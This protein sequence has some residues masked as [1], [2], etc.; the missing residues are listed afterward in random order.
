MVGRLLVLGARR[1]QNTQSGL[2][3]LDGGA[4]RDGGRKH[5]AERRECAKCAFLS[6]LCGFCS[7]QVNDSQQVELAVFRLEN[8][9]DLS[10]RKPFVLRL[11]NRFLPLSGA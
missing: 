3:D 9:P 10:A 11:T 2:D 4:V 7:A 5:R 1:E 6:A 8:P